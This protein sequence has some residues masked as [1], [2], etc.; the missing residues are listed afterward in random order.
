M[1]PIMTDGKR[2]VTCVVRDNGTW[3]L[4]VTVHLSEDCLAFDTKGSASVIGNPIFEKVAVCKM[5]RYFKLGDW[6]EFPKATIKRENAK[7]LKEKMLVRT[8]KRRA[9]DRLL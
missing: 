7:L 9:I 2:F 6:E 1:V 4:G 5:C 8:M 3:Q